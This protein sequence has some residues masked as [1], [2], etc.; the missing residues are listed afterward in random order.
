MPFEN[1]HLFILLNPCIFSPYRFYNSML[2]CRYDV[3]KKECNF[4]I[5]KFYTDLDIQLNGDTLPPDC[6]I[7][8]NY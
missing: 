2:K 8:K 3:L 6:R 7:S 5:A 4:D 1:H